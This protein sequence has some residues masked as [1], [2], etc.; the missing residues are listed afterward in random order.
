MASDTVTF[1]AGDLAKELTM[2]V[3]IVGLNLF[4]FRVRIAVWL[5]RIAAKIAGTGIEVNSERPN[6]DG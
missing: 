5:I 3:K 2:N 1:I 4:R 6:N